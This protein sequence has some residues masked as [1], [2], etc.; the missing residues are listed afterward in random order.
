MSK[1]AQRPLVV[2]TQNVALVAAAVLVLAANLDTV[3]LAKSL[4]SDPAARVKLVEI[5]EQNVK[6]APP[7]AEAKAALQKAQSAMESAGLQFGW[8]SFLRDPPLTVTRGGGLLVSIFAVSLGA[9]FWFDVLQRFM[10]VRAAGAAPGEREKNME[11]SMTTITSGTA[12]GG[13][14]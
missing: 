12:R 4:A 1:L 2:S 8:R 6:T 13:Q 14:R 7:S 3:D 11:D 10:R 5:A 9:P